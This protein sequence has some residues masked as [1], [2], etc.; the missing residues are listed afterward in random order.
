MTRHPQRVRALAGASNFRD[1]GG[2]LG[3]GGRR[4]R[5][6]RLYR[7]DHLADLTDA[8]R[9]ALAALGLRRSFDFRG[10]HERAAKAYEL[11]GVRQHALSIEPSVVQQQQALR[12]AGRTMTAALMGELMCDLY[13]RLVGERRERFAEF[14]DHL[15]R[16]EGPLVFHC[17]AGKDRTGV[18]AALVLMALGVERP[19]VEA[20]YLLTND[21]FRQPS[22]QAGDE[23]PPQALAVLW[24]VRED[25]LS[26]AFAVIEQEFGGIESYLRG[27]MGLDAARRARLREL[28]LEPADAGGGGSVAGD[29][30]AGGGAG[31][32]A[33]AKPA[34][35]A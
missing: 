6:G 1:L 20:D 21:V 4:V 32:G 29:A 11:P 13:R 12:A 17:T 26:A 31:A 14:F 33:A 15:L 24:R 23:L 18:A 34:G 7:S 35:A 2:Y 28:Y 16:D 22:P 9:Q 30:G 3:H 10:Q 5:W 27:P 19:V 25:F 8:D